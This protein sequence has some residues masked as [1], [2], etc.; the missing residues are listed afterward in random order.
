MGQ[1]NY[2]VNDFENYMLAATV[3]YYYRKASNWIM[4]DSRHDYMLMVNL[5]IC[6][7]FICLC[8]LLFDL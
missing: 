4:K 7:H 8:Y 1:M 2:Y 6:C 3:A 5:I